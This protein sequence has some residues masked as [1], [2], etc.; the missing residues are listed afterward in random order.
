MRRPERSVLATPG[1]DWH[2]IE[3][4]VASPADLVFLD[5]E[6]AIA[7][8][9]KVKSRAVV[10]HA[11]NNLDWGRKPKT[12]RINALDTPYFYRDLIDVIEA[13]A[14]LVDLVIVPKVN[15]AE[16]VYVVETLLAAIEGAH[17]IARPIGLQVQIETA[18]GLLNCERIATASARIESIVFGPGDFAA[19]IRMPVAS[20]GAPDAWDADYPGHRY[21]DAMSRILVSGRAA[22]IRVIDGPYG[23]FLD[24]DGL[25]AS[26][27]RARAL[28]F[29]G[30]W[31]I[32]P[33]QIE[34][35]NAQF[36]PTAAEIAWAE[37]IVSAANAAEGTGRG[38]ADVEGT[39]IDGASV[40]MA[41]VT[42]EQADRA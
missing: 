36:T 28:G 31:C 27:R 8:S 32:H 38:A 24:R 37:K 23:D 16:D 13:S 11:F 42:L 35:V 10:A 3:K 18:Q 14:G 4:A 40:R 7:A 2:M 21:H 41:R 26:C 19:S 17:R 34:V 20:I 6:D 30:K 39:M 1:S 25:A 12:Y 29:D 22:G 5:L 33:G 9:E 15:R